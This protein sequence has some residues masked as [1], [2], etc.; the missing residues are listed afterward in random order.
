MV[1]RWIG[2]AALVGG[3]VLF[4]IFFRFHLSTFT[5]ALVLV[6][7]LLSA[8]LSL[9]AAL[10]CALK[11]A[12]SLPRAVQGSQG[13]FRLRAA[14][15]AGL[16]LPGLRVRLSWH[17][18]LTGEAGEAVCSCPFPGRGASAEVP[19]ALPHCGR[20]GCRARGRALDLL[21]LI[22]LPL[23]MSG[24]AALLVLP[25][26]MDCPLP[27]ELALEQRRGAAL[28]PRPGGGP[29]EDY[30]LRDYRP[31]D[32]MKNIHWKLS[33]KRDELV[34]RET[35]EPRYAQVVLTYD[36]FGPPEAL[37]RA[38]ARLAALSRALL[39]QER[40]HQIRW[41]HPVT[42]QV[43]ARGVDSPDSLTACLE[44][45]FSLPAPA[46]GRSILDGALRAPGGD[47][48]PL[49]F[50]VAPAGKGAQP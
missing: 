1:R 14:N 5:L 13:S 20:V 21:G 38:F 2:Y 24:E 39:E 11:P 37:D 18:Q 22:P 32:P 4:Q 23:R 12:P 46:E 45:A 3:A 9:P 29:G 17:N 25:R 7:P 8:V 50:H 15:R 47:G 16:P 27:P 10:G 33:S 31:G 43:Y 28:R 19:L 40:P 34:V 6:L 36:H 44:A 41:A 26:E 48:P 30:D 35:L 42:G 49:H